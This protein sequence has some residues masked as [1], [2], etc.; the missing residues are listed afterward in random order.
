MTSTK[1]YRIRLTTEEQKELKALVSRGRT[2]AYKQTHARILLMSDELRP[3][4]GMTDED[5]SRALGV[6]LSMVERVRRRCV[7]GGIDRALNRKRQLRRRQKR[8][9]GEGEARLIAMACGEPPEGRARWTL[10]PNPPKCALTIV[11]RNPPSPIPAPTLHLSVDSGLVMTIRD[12]E[13]DGC[14]KYSKSSPQA[15]QSVRGLAFSQNPDRHHIRGVHDSQRH[16]PLRHPRRRMST[17]QEALRR[18]IRKTVLTLVAAGLLVR[19]RSREGST[20]R[21]KSAVHP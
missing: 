8:L 1:K 20:A 7:E 11:P 17:R 13:D 5:I 10:N 18:V 14:A 4:G 19:T 15:C 12:S 2:A 21:C 16:P 6:G 9:D 3:D